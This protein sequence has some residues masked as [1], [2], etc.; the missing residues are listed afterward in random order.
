MTPANVP[1][2]APAG[3]SIA[4]LMRTTA[5]ALVVAAVILVAFVLPA[6]YAIDPLG[7][8]RWL[9]LTEIAAP[10]V[11]VSEDPVPAGAAMV[12]VQSGPIGAY[13]G[14]FKLDV[15]EIE[16]AP[17]EYVEYKYRLE[18][19]AMMLYSWMATAGVIHDFHGERPAGAT[20]GPAEESFDKQERRHASGSYAA[21]FPGI[22]GWYWENPG[23]EPVTIRLTTAGFYTAATE[24][25]SDRSRHPRAL[26]T[27]ASLASAPAG[28]PRPDTN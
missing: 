15:F 23:A 8:G 19:D 25:R 13:P 3:P 14:E 5:V 27:I 1:S 17:Y 12:P 7:T 11:M 20:D 6:E 26:R 18:K 22:H 9:G 28:T 4:T 16:L 2:S 10:S 24:I 21:P